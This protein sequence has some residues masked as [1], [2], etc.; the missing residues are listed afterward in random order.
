[1][2]SADD[3]V[4]ETVEVPAPTT[5]GDTLRL[6]GTFARPRASS[7]A[8]RPAVL[9]ISGSGPQ[10][11]DGTRAEL[12]GYRP[13]RTLSDT[14]VARG[15]T[16]LRL[17]DR[18]TGASTGHF[19]GSTTVD[20]AGDAAAAVAWLRRRPD[21]DPMR[22]ALVGHSEGA[23]VAM[24]VAAQDPALRALAL[25]GAPSRSG[26][27]IARWQRQ[28]VVLR[29]GAAWPPD[30][31]A[32]VLAAAEREAERLAARDPWLRVWFALDPRAAARAVRQRVLLVHGETDRQVPVA[33][34]SELA[35]ALRS[36]GA[37]VSVVRA[38]RTDHLLLTDDDGDPSG[39]VRLADRTVRPAVLGEIA[40]FLTSIF[41]AT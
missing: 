21:V 39:Y 11:R 31:R 24:L 13:W 8:R 3:G 17:D 38:A 18:G 37:T 25:L 33:Q 1:V 19:A 26:R 23:L 6:A 22:I 27:E 5:I 32:S 28:A 35:E 14:L 20:F 30:Q 10:D 40:R 15:I 41:G 7:P 36:G 16:V 2:A 9:L 34:V 4:E 29:D 12:P